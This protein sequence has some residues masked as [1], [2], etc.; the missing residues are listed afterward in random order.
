[1]RILKKILFSVL[2]LATA[3]G[4]A[5][6]KYVPEDDFLFRGGKIK[7]DDNAESKEVSQV[8]SELEK[9]LYPEPN[10]KFLGM[11][12]KLHFYYASR[13]D[14]PGFINRFL[15]KK[16]G[17]DPA[18]FSE[19]NIEDTE[20]LMQNRLEN[21][22][23]FFGKINHETTLDSVNKT[24]KVDYEVK[25]GKPYRL[26]VYK[27]E[28]DTVAPDKIYDEI[29]ENLNETELKKGRNFRLADLK[30][31]RDRIDDDLKSK[32]YYYFNKDFIEFEAD[33]NRYG[34]KKFDLYLK[35]K[36][37]V[38]QKALDP[39][40]LD[41]VHVYANVINDT[42]YGVQDT[43]RVG[44]IDVIQSRTQFKPKRLKPFVLLEPG[45]LYSP[46][47]SQY[48]SRRLSSIGNYKFVNVYYT[49]TD[50]IRDEEGK[51]HL[52]SVITLSPLEKRSIQLKLQ[53]VSKSNNF[54]GPGVGATY[55]NRNIFKGGENLSFDGNFG[56][57]KQ[58]SSGN[59]GGGSRSIQFGLK[60]SLLFPRL[61]FPGTY[62]H[63]FEY[64]IP[65]TRVTA[66]VDYLNR[67]KLYT[68]NSFSTAFGYIW[69]QN[70]FV[71]HELSLVSLD[72]IKL[73]NTSTRFQ[74]ILDNNIFLKKSFEQQFIA[75]VNYSFTY[76]ELAEEKSRGQF[77]I[78]FNMDIAGNGP[79]LLARK[80][81]DDT[82]KFLGLKYA[83]Y[84]KADVDVSYH[85]G[86]N[87]SQTQKLAGHVFMGYGLPYGNSRSLPFVK[88]YFAGGPY[89]VRAFNIRSLGPGTYKPA[90][91]KESYFDQAGD[92]RFEANLEYRFPIV[93]FLKGAV[94]ADAGNVWLQKENES[95]PG[96]KF[97]KNFIHELG[98]GTGV[99]L[100]VDIQGFVIRFD[101][102]SA[103][104]RPDE[105]WN[106]EYNKPVF[107]FGIGYPF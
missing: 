87:E 85:F 61:L 105:N 22:G 25:V 6:K 97:S 80:S 81:S 18:Y 89:S 55:T 103:L 53:G 7:V 11:Y 57:E 28:R 27:V 19:V 82:K 36:K 86:L 31:E 104:K 46:T 24:A 79:D 39:Y 54:T 44:N 32:G 23:F 73:S 71:T 91:D 60:G 47:K 69:E 98:F 42:V 75:G 29:E 21:N 2:I 101:L 70:R 37:E 20:E 1:M 78:Q 66:G 41:S 68:L 15:G 62:D 16:L 95:L 65:K 106:F 83:Q 72:Y 74:E 35:L 90:S 96:G 13:Q 4:C 51:R 102:S 3:Y 67:S 99:G 56:F 63:L 34:D 49:E 30:K 33:T 10:S 107:N 64:S 45:E 40:Q 76:N 84:A 52:K 12:P 5:V 48:T 8:K 92:I 100:R 9:I 43:T 59:K 88:Q 94:F 26:E 38:P 77:Y 93:S 58:F 17:E 50:S 14:N